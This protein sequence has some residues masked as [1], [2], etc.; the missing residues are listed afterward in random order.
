MYTEVFIYNQNVYLWRISTD[1]SAC[2]DCR[3][4]QDQYI[5]L[6]SHLSV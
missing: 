2:R 5:W 6:I 3:N 1:A 4:L